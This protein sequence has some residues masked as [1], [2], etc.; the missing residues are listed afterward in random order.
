MS[1]LLGLTMQAQLEKR[2]HSLREEFAQGQQ[3]LM[4]LSN[5]QRDLQQTLLRIQGAIQ[6][7]EEELAIEQSPDSSVTPE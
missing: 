1:Q 6:V 4:E 2:L 3:V 7:L 5:K